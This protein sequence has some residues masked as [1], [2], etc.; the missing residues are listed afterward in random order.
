MSGNALDRSALV[1][2][3]LPHFWR[4]DLF[5]K[6]GS[7]LAGCVQSSLL[8]GL[9]DVVS[10]EPIFQRLVDLR[11][12]PFDLS[13][14]FGLSLSFHR[15]FHRIDV[16]IEE[17]SGKREQNGQRDSN[18]LRRVEKELAIGVRLVALRPAILLRFVAEKL[19]NVHL[20]F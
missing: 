2:D 14:G 1:S 18:D 9:L 12:H 3:G 16:A 19:E 13:L 15:F 10:L 8:N 7:L 11:V 4:N 5:D 6:A 20:V 17:N